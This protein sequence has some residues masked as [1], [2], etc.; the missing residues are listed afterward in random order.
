MWLLT[1][2]Y[3]GQNMTGY[4]LVFFL[5][6]IVKGLGVSDQHDRLVSALPYPV[7]FRGDALLGLAFRPHR[8]A[9]LARGRCMLAPRRGMAACVFIGVGHPVM[10]MIALIFAMMGNRSS[11]PVVLVA[12]QRVADRHGRGGW[13]RPDQC[14]R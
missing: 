9:D 5:P 7:G 11:A 3:F 14:G 13:H 4:G 8:R 12:A 1:I 10:M 2:A 6:L